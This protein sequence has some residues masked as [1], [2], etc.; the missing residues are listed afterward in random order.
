M[1]NQ[2]QERAQELRRQLNHHN[3]L[4]FVEN[5]PEISDPEFDRLFR[6]LEE[7]EKAHPELLTPDSPTQRVGGAV[8]PEFAEVTHR[9]PM[10]SIGKAMK[11]DELFDFDK[12][13]RKALN[14]GEPVK[15]VVELKIDGTAV[16]MTY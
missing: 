9:V 10:L 1:A 2:L 6:E 5:K 12:R 3:Y 15:Y 14:P 13:V 11:D 4:Y 16:S 8:L 7:L